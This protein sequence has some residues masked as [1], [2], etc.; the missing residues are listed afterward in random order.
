MLEGQRKEQLAYFGDR[1]HALWPKLQAATEAGD[2]SDFLNECTERAYETA[3]LFGVISACQAARRLAEAE[4]LRVEAQALRDAMDRS[5]AA[6]AARKVADEHGRKVRR[7]I[8]DHLE[9]QAA[10]L[11]KRARAR[12]LLVHPDAKF[13]LEGFD[14]AACGTW[15]KSS[16]RWESDIRARFLRYVADAQERA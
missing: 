12:A 1:G 13:Q 9:A 16:Q 4:Q 3:R 14:P 7:F 8:R 5:D 2:R 11:D 6:V 10:S 15:P